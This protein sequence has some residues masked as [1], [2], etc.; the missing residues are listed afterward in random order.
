MLQGSPAVRA[1]AE[2]ISR[3]QAARLQV[4]A[5]QTRNIREPGRLM[6]RLAQAAL[7]SPLL[8]SCRLSSL[9]AEAQ[10]RAETAKKQ[11]IEAEL[12]S[13][14]N[15]IAA[16]RTIAASPR[17][18]GGPTT[19][20]AAAAVVAVPKSSRLRVNIGD[21]FLVDFG[22]AAGMPPPTVPPTDEET[23]RWR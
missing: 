16:I 2:E 12:S 13:A 1:A 10:L 8:L 9:Q 6:L 7:C 20:A 3:H 19:A 4:H 5:A 17:R 22:A 23:A 21:D 11:A 18:P 15:A 14:A